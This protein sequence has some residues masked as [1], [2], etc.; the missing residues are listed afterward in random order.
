MI[1][2]APEEARVSA[3][4]RSRLMGYDFLLLFSS[5]NA[6]QEEENKKGRE[7]NKRAAAFCGGLGGDARTIIRGQGDLG[8]GYLQNNLSKPKM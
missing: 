6:T 3:V 4:G 8:Q 5:S 1:F 2:A 7:N